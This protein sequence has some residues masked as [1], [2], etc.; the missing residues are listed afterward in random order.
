MA[1]IRE[2]FLT[3]ELP[4]TGDLNRE[5]LLASK[6]DFGISVTLVSFSRSRHGKASYSSSYDL[7]R[8]I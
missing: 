5:Y 7:S 1:P 6:A 8:A 4:I 2:K 3:L